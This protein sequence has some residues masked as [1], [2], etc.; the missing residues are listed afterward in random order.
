MRKRHIRFFFSLV[1]T[2]LTRP[3]KIIKWV[4]S[5]TENRQEFNRCPYSDMKINLITTKKPKYV[6]STSISVHLIVQEENYF[7]KDQP[8]H[9]LF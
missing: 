7:M 2:I 3:K 9:N 1:H 5:N 4:W 8:V 6:K